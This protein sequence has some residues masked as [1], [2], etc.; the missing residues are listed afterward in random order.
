M[1][2]DHLLF[3]IDTEITRLQQARTLLAGIS[4]ASHEGKPAAPS[5]RKVRRK[6]SAE[7]RARIAEAQRKRWAA[8]KKA[9][10]K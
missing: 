4:T 9:A 8:Q 1:S 7:A 6:L 2:L 10:A 3:A 5:E